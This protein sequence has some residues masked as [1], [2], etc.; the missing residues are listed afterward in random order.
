M[1]TLAAH[2]EDPRRSSRSSSRQRLDD[3]R[4]GRKI[5]ETH[6]TVFRLRKKTP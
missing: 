5:V 2:R 3:M 4:H 6:T 1:L